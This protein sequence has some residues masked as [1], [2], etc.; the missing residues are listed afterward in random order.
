M[1]MSETHSCRSCPP[2][3]C[4]AQVAH[5]RYR[6][7]RNGVPIVPQRVGSVCVSNVRFDALSRILEARCGQL[8]DTPVSV[9]LRWVQGLIRDL[10]TERPDAV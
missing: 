4:G 1:S 6:L 10:F 7:V 9:E 5:S 3:G 8:G 2:E